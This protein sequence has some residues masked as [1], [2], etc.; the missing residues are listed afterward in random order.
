M[1]N[2]ILGATAVLAGINTYTGIK[3]NQ[4]RAKSAKRQLRWDNKLLARQYQVQK[5]VFEE[6]T[7]EYAQICSYSIDKLRQKNLLQR[8]VIGYNLLKSGLAITPED[9]AGQL[10]R[11]QAHE[12]EM[13]A[14]AQEMQM[15]HNRPKMKIDKEGLDLQINQGRQKI[16]DINK[17]TPW[18]SYAQVGQGL[19]SIANSYMNYQY[20]G[21][22][23][24]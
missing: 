5:K 15:Y 12:D 21:R 16:I 2:F 23:T 18:A 17:A 3:A 7:D 9:S 22:N 20:Q 19:S 10:I 11:F 4:A 1:L 24:E 8:Q 14:R 6:A 13:G